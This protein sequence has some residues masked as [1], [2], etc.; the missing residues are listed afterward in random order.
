MKNIYSVFLLLSLSF[1][2]DA[3]VI[4][5][6]DPNFKARLLLATISSGVASDI[7]HNFVKI[8]TND[9]NEIDVAE[10]SVI[11]YLE[12]NSGNINSLS[13]IEN[14]VNL[15]GLQC[16]YNNVTNLSPISNLTQ[17]TYLYCQNNQITS[18][19]AI[20]NLTGLTDLSVS[21]N[22]VTA[23]NLSN[24]NQLWRL[25]AEYTQL[26]EINLCGTVVTWLWATEN[27][28]L[29]SLYL[30]NGVVSNDLAKNSSQ[31]PPP[32][33]NFGF[34]NNPALTYICYDEG[35]LDAVMYGIQYNTAGKTLTTSCNAAC[36][37]SV[38]NL[39]ADNQV[40]FYPNPTSGL[41]NIVVFNNQLIDKIVVSDILGQMI[42]SL[43]NSTLLDI[44]SLS[45][46]TYFVTVETG[47]GKETQRIIKQ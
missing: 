24:L 43:G 14:F 11:Y 21:N 12:V 18:L 34:Y 27:P 15:R 9:D 6:P 35:E 36:A 30:K 46:G 10:A 40:S 33:H 23:I 13:G 5:F 38:D 3:Q 29:T 7:N 45:K 26:T 16:Y 47:S 37:L 28:N 22:P 39:T 17:L 44:S 31:I 42:I 20:E 41:L 19:T 25:W 1:S 32:L 4:N 8:D 2:T